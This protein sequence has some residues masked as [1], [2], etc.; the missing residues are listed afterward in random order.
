M[1]RTLGIAFILTSGFVL[2][3]VLRRE[4]ERGLAAFSALLAFI[5]Y[6]TVRVGTYLEPIYLAA[7]KYSAEHTDL[8]PL[9]SRLSSGVGLGEALAESSDALGLGDGARRIIGNVLDGALFGTREETCRVLT[10]LGE[11][12][13]AHY[14]EEEEKAMKKGK[15]AF[16]L[17]LSVAIGIAILL[18]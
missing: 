3:R 8:S 16:A 1:I 12:L 17:S 15:A 14:A 2:G 10:A 4:C 13:S 9:L 5:R 11:S 6:L 18:V 7:E